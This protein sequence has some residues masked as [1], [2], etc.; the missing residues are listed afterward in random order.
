M[1]RVTMLDV[2]QRLHAHSVWIAILLTVTLTCFLFPGEKAGYRVIDINDYRGTYNSA[3]M[4]TSLALVGSYLL[5]I[6]GYYWLNGS[7]DRD[8]QSKML[9]LIHTTGQ[10]PR[11]YL[12]VRWTGHVILLSLLAI[13]S[14]VTAGILQ[15][16][17]SPESAI[18][19]A[20]YAVPFFLLVLPS[21]LLTSAFILLFDMWQKPGSTA[22]N[23]L[24]FLSW[25]VITSAGLLGF[26]AHTLVTSGMESDFAHLG[27]TG[28]GSISIGFTPLENAQQIVNWQGLNLSLESW[29]PAVYHLLTT[30]LLLMICLTRAKKAIPGAH[31][32]RHD[33]QP[34]VSES[35]KRHGLITWLVARSHLP[36]QLAEHVFT[37]RFCAEVRLIEHTLSAKL[38]IVALGVSALSLVLPL[39]AVKSVILAVA[40]T[41]PVLMLA[42]LHTLDHQSKIKELLKTLGQTGIQRLRRPLA[43]FYLINLSLA[44]VTIRFAITGEITAL[45]HWLAFLTISVFLPYLLATFTRSNKVFELLFISFWVTG[46]LNKEPVA[47]FVGVSGS[48]T[49]MT[50]TLAFAGGCII[51]CVFIA[52]LN[53][54]FSINKVKKS[55]A[56]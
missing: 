36:S 43:M 16:F 5:S 40:V 47:D 34:T 29:L 3:W 8:R 37:H 30:L 17:L 48:H 28:T 46:I 45:L 44:G 50:V 1:W 42:P 38:L 21:I 49:A 32:K 54:T 12:L 39:S 35:S 26:S 53:P 56:K 22:K 33:R 6:F 9:E 19:F 14:M 11:R 52:L 2:K 51:A 13:T 27:M 25:S 4:G 18:M 7:V 41:L 31:N 55:I 20:D 23:W 24:Y 10:S 15:C